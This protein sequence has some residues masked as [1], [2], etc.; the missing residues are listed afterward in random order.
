M[1][2]GMFSQDPNDS[3]KPGELLGP[4]A[5]KDA[6]ERANA[7]LGTA[8]V[9][10]EGVDIFGKTRAKEILGDAQQSAQSTANRAGAISGGLDLIGSVGSFGASG[11][12]GGSAFDYNMKTPSVFGNFG[13]GVSGQ[14]Y[15]KII[16]TAPPPVPGLP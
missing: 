10:G 12:F 6:K 3:F 1:A 8:L 14:P 2:F 4:S 5:Q 11:G 9:G 16:P 7:F 15:A 13:G